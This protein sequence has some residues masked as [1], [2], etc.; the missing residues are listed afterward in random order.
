MVKVIREWGGFLHRFGNKS[1]LIGHRGAVTPICGTRLRVQS[2]PCMSPAIE[3]PFRPY[4]YAMPPRW[5]PWERVP[6]HGNLT[7]LSNYGAEEFPLIK[8]TN[9]GN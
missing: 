3:I 8:V 2:E 7:L 1:S 9:V 5:N 6:G 4:G